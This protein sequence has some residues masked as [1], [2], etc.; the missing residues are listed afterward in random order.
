MTSVTQEAEIAGLTPGMT[1][2]DAR[3]ICPAVET[4]P[5]DPAADAALLDRLVAWCA[6]YTPWAAAEGRDGVFS[7]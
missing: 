1:L 3:A 2:P 7:M 5:A 4:A 6:R